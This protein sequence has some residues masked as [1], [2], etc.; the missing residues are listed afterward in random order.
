MVETR[1]L[2]GLEVP[3]PGDWEDFSS[4]VFFVPPEAQD[5]AARPTMQEIRE[6]QA[7]LVVTRRARQPR[8]QLATYFEAANAELVEQETGFELRAAG[9]SRYRGRAA[10]WQD[11]SRL[12]PPS[13]MQVAQRNI[14]VEGDA[15]EVVMLTLTGSA[16]DLVRMSTLLGFETAPGEG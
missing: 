16:R 8:Q 6:L 14:A 11:I 12:H 5:E 1:V 15:D 2:H 3:V 4:Y 13:G 7:N 10:A 9:L